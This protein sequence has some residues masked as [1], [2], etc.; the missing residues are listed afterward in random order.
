MN[1]LLRTN[2]ALALLIL[3]VVNATF[4]DGKVFVEGENCKIPANIPESDF[5]KYCPGRI[6]KQLTF[7]AESISC[8]E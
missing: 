5:K 7:K 4:K 6:G 1:V 2:G 8:Y 3:N